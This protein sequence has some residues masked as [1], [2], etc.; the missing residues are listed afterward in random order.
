[1]STHVSELTFLEH[2]ADRFKLPVPK[3]LDWTN[4]MKP[5]ESEDE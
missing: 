2:L 1:M 4:R 5:M 3:H